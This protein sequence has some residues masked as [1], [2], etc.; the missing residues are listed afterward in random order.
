MRKAGYLYAPNIGGAKKVPVVI[1]ACLTRK[2]PTRLR[3]KREALIN[4]LKGHTGWDV[5]Y[6]GAG[7]V[8][9]ILV[10][11]VASSAA[12]VDHAAEIIKKEIQDYLQETLS[13]EKTE[14]PAMAA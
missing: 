9:T 8:P 1:T 2:V 14:L 5:E 11:F 7:H 10:S 4:H 6:R 13:L 12:D 3:N